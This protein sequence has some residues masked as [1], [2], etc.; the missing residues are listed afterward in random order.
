[1]TLYCIGTSLT[2]QVS[3]VK[4]LLIHAGLLETVALRPF[5]A[6]YIGYIL[7]QRIW[8]KIQILIAADPD[9]G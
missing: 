9:V 7:S 1:M 6:G 3:L 5:L 4:E 2:H 8:T